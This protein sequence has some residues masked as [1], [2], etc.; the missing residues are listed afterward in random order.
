MKASDIESSLNPIRMR[1]L[2][3]LSQNREMNTAQIRENMEDISQATLYRHINA[4]VK[5]NLI[6]VVKENRI[7]GAVEKI[8]S[9]NMEINCNDP[10]D[11]EIADLGYKFILS[12]LGELTNYAKLKDRDFKKD[13]VSFGCAP[14]YLTDEEFMDVMSEL[15]PVLQKYL[16]NKAGDG[17]T[18]RNIY[19]IAI[20]KK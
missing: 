11:D 18:L 15:G 17:R 7:R 13:M 5:A 19:T 10:S 14:L 16:S 20:P 12:I 1:I 8:Y 3:L 4:L 2:V 6:N 9:I